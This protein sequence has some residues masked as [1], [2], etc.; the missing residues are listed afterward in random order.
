MQRPDRLIVPALAPLYA[1]LSDFAWPLVR[2]MFGFFFIPYG[3]QKLFGW[4]GGNI[5]GTMKAMASIGLEPAAFWAYYTGTL[6]LVG[7][8]MLMVG[9]FTRPVAVL[10]AASM[11]MGTFFVHWQFGYSWIARG[12]SA[13]LLLLVLSVAFVIRGGGEYSLDRA[14]GREL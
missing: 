6:E 1:S 3:C 5:A 9:L 11:F 4:F 7:G 14:L 8:A 13:P 10:M 2:V 12:F